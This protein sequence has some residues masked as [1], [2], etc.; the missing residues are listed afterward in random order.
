LLQAVISLPD[1][2]SQFFFVLFGSQAMH[3]KL[4]KKRKMY[5]K[6][7]LFWSRASSDS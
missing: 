2:I 7:P 4:K 6:L 5:E 3:E 1:F